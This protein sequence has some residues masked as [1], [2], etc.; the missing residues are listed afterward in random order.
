MHC[1]SFPYDQ[2]NPE[3]EEKQLKRFVRNRLNG[4]C[5]YCNKKTEAMTV[6][7]V[8]PLKLGGTNELSN[9]VPACSD[10]NL[11]KG[12]KDVWLWWQQQEFFNVDRA[13]HLLEIMYPEEYWEE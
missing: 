9:L 1:P 6:D 3:K 10:C 5:I 11:R 13:F 12:H 8:V 7:H 4:H 2:H